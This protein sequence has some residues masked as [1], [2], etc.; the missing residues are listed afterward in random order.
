MT[1][2]CQR[3]T[4]SDDA[5]FVVASTGSGKSQPIIASAIEASQ[6]NQSIVIVHFPTLLSQSFAQTA[7]EQLHASSGGSAHYMA[8]ESSAAQASRQV[9]ALFDKLKR[10]VPLPSLIVV[11]VEC[12]KHDQVCCLLSQ[13][14]AQLTMRQQLI[15]I[16]FDEA[17]LIIGFSRLHIAI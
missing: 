6:T 10:N 11:N 5:F 17:H 15:G 4:S 9:R 8:F 13:F 16:V 1:L 2:F 14:L 12:L 3:N 7:F